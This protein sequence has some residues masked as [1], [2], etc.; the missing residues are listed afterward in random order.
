MSKPCKLRLRPIGYGHPGPETL[1]MQL[2]AAISLFGETMPQH[3]SDMLML[4]HP[5]IAVLD[6]KKAPKGSDGRLMPIGSRAW[7]T[8][9]TNH[10]KPP[11][12]T[13]LYAMQLLNSRGDTSFANM[14]LA[15][16][17]LAKVKGAEV[18]SLRTVNKI[19]DHAYVSAK[20]R[21]RFSSHQFHPLIR[22][23]PKTGKQGIYL[24]PGKT[25]RI[26]DMEPDV[27]L[28]IVDNLLDR[29]ISPNVIYRHQWCLGDLVF[30]DKR[31]AMHQAHTDYDMQ[32]G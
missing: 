32:A 9:H 14:Q 25:E 6:S 15:H 7:H 27:S 13:A 21:E 16:A 24:H 29:K 19:E 1:P 18:V 22:T 8:D 23:H 10:A 11:K 2:L 28:V 20:D 17:S 30:W 31:G 5:D 12:V 4:G 26:E 3:L